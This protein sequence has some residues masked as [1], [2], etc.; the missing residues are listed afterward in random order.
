MSINDFIPAIAPSILSA[1]FCNLEAA[2]KQVAC[3]GTRFVH[4]DVMDGH[5]VPN[6]TI[7]QPVV[8]A[9]RSKT[10]LILDVHLMIENPDRYLAGF[11]RAGADIITVHQEACPH[12]NRTLNKIKDLGKK[13]GVALNPA[14]PLSTLE[15][16]WNLADLVLLMSVNPG[17]GGQGFIPGVSD[18]LARAGKIKR[19]ND[20]RFILEVDGGVKLNNLTEVAGAGAELLVAGSAVFAASSPPDEAL[21]EM[22]S[23]LEK[24]QS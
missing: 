12:L 21:K 2:L 5:F 18:K 10:D 19:E 7:G 9:L 20:Y 16:V 22:K 15:E 3:G 14:T 6:I 4:I 8:Q 1:D 24:L 13:A 23:C 17:F 11:A